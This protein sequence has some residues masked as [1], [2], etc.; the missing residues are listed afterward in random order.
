VARLSVVDFT[1]EKI[2]PESK[3]FYFS[4][5]QT[6]KTQFEIGAY[7]EKVKCPQKF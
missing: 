2:I 5:F 6:T 1:D 7:S 3:K 4:K